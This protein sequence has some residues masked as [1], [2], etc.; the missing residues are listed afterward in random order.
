MGKTIVL[1]GIP[2]ED[3]TMEEA[4]ARCE[5]YIRAGRATGR[6][7]YVATANADFAVLGLKD[8]ELIRLLLESDMTT[9][10]GMPL[11]WGARLLGL[12]IEGR[13]TG[14][15]MVP[16]LAEL[17]A[18]NGFSVF[19]LGAREGVAARTAEILLQRF[20]GLKIAGTY[21]PAPAPLLEMDPAIVERVRAARP[22]LLL[23][24]LGTPKQEKWIKMHLFNLQVP[25]SIGVG[26][27][28]DFIVGEQKRAPV[29]MQ[30]AGLEWLFR[31]ASQPQ[32]LW[33][34]YV[35]DMFYFSVFFVRQ[36]WEMR[37]KGAPTVP[38]PQPDLSL[39]E[40]VPVLRIVGRLDVGNQD[41]FIA[42][43]EQSLAERPYL[44]VDMGAATFLD[45]SALGALVALT[46][47]ARKAGGQLW[48]VRVPVPIIQIFTMMR[49]EHFFDIRAD[50]E[51]AIV[52][53]YT[54]PEPVP[55]PE[56][57]ATGWSVAKMPRVVDATNA[58]SL[59]VR[60]TASLG[61]SPWMVLDFSEAVFL[62]SAGLAM[63]VK[64]NRAAEERGG[65]LLVAGCTRDVA[66]TIQMVRLDQ[67]LTVVD[68]LVTATSL[69]TTPLAPVPSPVSLPSPNRT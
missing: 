37:V 39:V 68:D 31:L 20:P 13:V 8:P 41:A 6:P 59:F 36:F 18:R 7:H 50:V 15:D 51:A 28:F 26:A 40:D 27:S 46:R 62:A 65:K 4:M 56:P 25:L 24:A 30:K 61:T 38:Q 10:D 66:R 1:L 12:P 3:L 42:R 2:V 33:K 29:W 63:M 67:V 19:L 44:I 43:A 11:V 47:A 17:C 54:D 16:A 35:L 60:C 9:A 14:A 34:R 32:R 64:L 22:D 48:L 5:A 69:P 45:S 52:Q 57:V 55:A 53:R 49:L 23:V 21:S 58:E